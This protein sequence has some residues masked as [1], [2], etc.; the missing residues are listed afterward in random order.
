MR[1]VTVGIVVVVF[2]ALALGQAGVRRIP[3]YCSNNCG[4]Y[5]PL[6]STPNVGF[7]TVS[8]SPVGASNA[9]GGL[10]AGA[11]NSTLSIVDG[12][13]DAVHTQVVWYSGGG[14]PLASPAVLLPHPQP[15]MG[16][17][18]EHMM[19]ME[20]E[21]GEEGHQAWTYYAGRAETASAV[22]ASAGAKNGRHAARTYTNQDVER[23]NE[24]N[25]EF[26]RK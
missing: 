23:M 26:K 5:I 16:M 1:A 18:E 7:E 8:P 17:H 24:K 9:T 15:M 19:H 22:E 6:I 4:P 14:S 13:P 10:H 25:Q 3:S 12:N 2:S 20:H 21:R 11:R